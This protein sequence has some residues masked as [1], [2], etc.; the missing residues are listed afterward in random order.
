MN[1]MIILADLYDDPLDPGTVDFTTKPGRKCRT[2]VFSRQK[3]V[4]CDEAVR[5]ALLA[6][7]DS[8][9]DRNVVYFVRVRDP[10]QVD[11]TKEAV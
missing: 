5:L 9:D 4:V 2:C 8:C 7:L 6:G 1:G 10:R 3:S 11:L